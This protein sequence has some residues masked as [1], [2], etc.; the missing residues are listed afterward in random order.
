MVTELGPPAVPSPPC[1]IFIDI[2]VYHKCMQCRKLK[3]DSS[4]IF[5]HRESKF[6]RY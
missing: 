2:I 5:F 1:K 4:D 3:G 6:L